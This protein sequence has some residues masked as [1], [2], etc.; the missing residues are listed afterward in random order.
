M[1]G[2]TRISSLFASFFDG[3][4]GLRREMHRKGGP[5]ANVRLDLNRSTMQFNQFLREGHSRPCGV[6]LNANATIDDL[7]KNISF[8]APEPKRHPAFR[9]RKP[10]RIVQQIH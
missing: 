10:H 5:F 2:Q 6:R 7:H 3:S 4:S 8:I 9:R 1:A